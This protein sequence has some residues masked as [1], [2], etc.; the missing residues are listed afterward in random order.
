MD[1]PQYQLRHHGA[2]PQAQEDVGRRGRWKQIRRRWWHVLRGV[3]NKEGHVSGVCKTFCA[4]VQV[5]IAQYNIVAWQEKSIFAPLII[6]VIII[7][8][9][10]TAYLK[11]HNQAKI[12][13]KSVFLFCLLNMTIWREH[14]QGLELRKFFNVC[15]AHLLI[16][17]D[18]KTKFPYFL[19]WT[20][21]SEIRNREFK[22]WA[23]VCLCT[24]AYSHTMTRCNYS[25][26]TC[27]LS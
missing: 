24:I 5:S 10:A 14:I 26:F 16:E 15:A 6:V 1:R 23:A 20:C 9:L 7:Y 21:M 11:R 8:C 13:E 19:F 17:R 12:I 2:V 25:T 3:E 4:Y 27:Q 22:K 18:I